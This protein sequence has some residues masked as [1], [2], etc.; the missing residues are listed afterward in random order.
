MRHIAIVFS[1]GAVTGMLAGKA[2]LVLAPDLSFVAFLAWT[3]LL[4]M[5]ANAVLL[6]PWLVE[7]GTR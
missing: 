4:S 3:M 7:E 2:V 5:A 6:T 1:V